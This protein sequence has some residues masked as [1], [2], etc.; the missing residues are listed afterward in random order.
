MDLINKYPYQ[1]FDRIELN[2]I[3]RYDIPGQRPL[4]S[5]TTILSGTKDNTPILEWRERVGDKEADRITDEA[6]AIGQQMHDNLENYILRGTQPQGRLLEQLL[7]KLVIK[8]GL[9]NVDEVW[10]C[11]VML[12]LNELYAGTTD[13]VGVHNGEPAIMDFKNSL[14]VKKREWIDDYFLQLVAYT[15]AHNERYNTD[16]KKGVIMMACRTGV[17]QEFILEGDEFKH[18]QGLWNDKLFEYYD[19]Y[20]IE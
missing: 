10:G 7:T 8:N 2:G 4:P 6:A 3:R 9:I 19:K 5:V 12:Y 20:G 15:D 14:K 13:L 1:T 18:Y 17:Y 11:E 16:I